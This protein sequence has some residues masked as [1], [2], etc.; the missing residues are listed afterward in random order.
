MYGI[1]IAACNERKIIP[2][3]NEIEKDCEVSLLL[4]NVMVMTHSLKHDVYSLKHDVYIFYIP[5]TFASSSISTHFINKI[6]AQ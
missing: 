2:F 1:S 6:P 4:N 3:F 5:I